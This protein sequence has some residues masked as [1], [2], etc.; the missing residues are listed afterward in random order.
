MPTNST[1]KIT[2]VFEGDASKLTA[3]TKAAQKAV[4]KF[5]EKT[6]DTAGG[7]NSGM[8]GI[9]SIAKKLVPAISAAFAVRELALFGKEAVQL[10]AKLEGIKRAFV[11]I[12]GTGKTSMQE[13]KAY[14]KGAVD[15]MTLMSLAVQAKNFKVPLENLGSFFEF[16]TIRA[17]ET[18]E[19]VEYLTRSIVT[20]IG[21]KSPLILDNLGITLV[22]LKEAMGKV[23]RESATVADISAAVAKIAKE[24][25]Y[26]IEKLG[27]AS[28]TTAQKIEKMGASYKNFKA[29]VGEDIIESS[30]FMGIA[31]A[32]EWRQDMSSVDRQIEDLK[33]KLHLTNLEATELGRAFTGEDDLRNLSLEQRIDLMNEYIRLNKEKLE[34]DKQAAIKVYGDPRLSDD[35]LAWMERT[36]DAFDKTSTLTNRWTEEEALDISQA[37][38]LLNEDA[39]KRES[40][41]S[42]I[43]NASEAKRLGYQDKYIE[44]LRKIA[45]EEKNK[46]ITSE[47]GLKKRKD[48]LDDLVVAGDSDPLLRNTQTYESARLTLLDINKELERRVQLMEKLK[49]SAA[50]T[51]KNDAVGSLSVRAT[52]TEGMDEDSLTSLSDEITA[53]ISVLDSG[54]D[55]SLI[56]SL[57]VD[58]EVVN[59]ALLKIKLDGLVPDEELNGL[60]T[61]KQEL[62]HI[63]IIGKETKMTESEIASARIVAIDAYIA[64]LVTSNE[65]VDELLRKWRKIYQ[66]IIDTNNETKKTTPQVSELSQMFS[67]MSIA[68]GQLASQFNPE[69]T[70]AKTMRLAQS[71]MVAAAA[72]AALKTALTGDLTGAAKTAAVFVGIAG[73]LGSTVGVASSIGGFGGGGSSAGYNASDG[74]GRL[75]TE[76][77][78]NDL[79]VILDRSN[80]FSNRRG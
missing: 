71:L 78:G 74:G 42:A 35:P 52:N 51:D 48:L 18:G 13:L 11:S 56:E 53:M 30:G 61:L 21:R 80:Q 32:I 25:V 1:N 40:E 5:N 73:L 77:R 45:Y 27:L 26:F 49:E 14:T 59:K 75:Y 7:K 33:E 72:A 69:S 76:I 36:A 29:S 54:T 15:E 65:E 3:A 2:V 24:E 67:S 70:I 55:T 58:L 20:G 19:S 17:A 28:T 4:D 8:A 63:G 37:L 6:K 66:V 39:K 31:G 16:A 47:E 41:L 43:K 50:A 64:K 9:L 44:G 60:A 22:R 10:G 62:N 68:F 34:A 23:G 57:L 46:A 79:R 38:R 12:E